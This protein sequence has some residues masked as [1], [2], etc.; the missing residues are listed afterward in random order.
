MI[1]KKDKWLFLY[2]LPCH[3]GIEEV[4]NRMME[5]GNSAPMLALNGNHSREDVRNYFLGEHNSR[6]G[7]M[8]NIQCML[9]KYEI[10]STLPLQG[11]AIAIGYEI[12]EYLRE[13]YLNEKDMEKAVRFG[14]LK[15][16][17]LKLRDIVFMHRGFIVDAEFCNGK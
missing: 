12:P 5:S 2:T 16:K 3:N 4:F 9:I 6:V 17:K 8:G 15:D 1:Q 13:V 11:K 14:V 7:D 10:I